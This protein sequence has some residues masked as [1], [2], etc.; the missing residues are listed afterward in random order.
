MTDLGVLPE[1]WCWGILEHMGQFNGG[2]TPSKSN[3][4][5]WIGGNIPWVSPK[6]MKT[7]HIIDTEDHITRL[8]L[9]E[10][11]LKLCPTNTVLV[12]IR[13]GILQHTFPVAIS[14][15]PITM[16]QDMKGICLEDEVSAMYIV[17]CLMALGRNIL[18]RCSKDGTTVSSIESELLKTYPLPLPPLTEQQQIVAV[19]EERLSLIEQAE[20]VVEVSL[21]RVE[22]ARQSI[23]KQ[24]FAGQLVP[25]DPDDE[26]ASVLLER[27]REERERR[28]IEEQLRKR[29]KSM[30]KPRRAKAKKATEKQPSVPLLEVLVDAKRP[31]AP[32]DLFKRAGLKADAIEDVGIFYDNLQEEVTTGRIREVRPDDTL[33]LLEPTNL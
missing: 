20:A 7:L 14:Q 17:Y 12:V 3:A 28:A 15:V 9:E 33:V 32:D 18:D 11:V 25:Q 29:E 30:N 26:H 8:A 13:S 16:N 2:G 10:T 24:A 22:R 27:I 23:L 31:L 19:V 1:G 5:Y 4:K 6:D 21:Q